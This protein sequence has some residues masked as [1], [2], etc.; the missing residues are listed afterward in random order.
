VG[1]ALQR[2]LRDQ[3]PERVRTGTVHT[4]QGGERDVVIFSLVADE[5]MHPGAIGW[6][7]RQLNLWNVAITRARSHLIVVGDAGLWQQRGGVGAAL[8][9]AS[10]STDAPDRADHDGYKELLKRL[11]TQLSDQPGSTVELDATVNG[12]RADAVT[13]SDQNVQAVLL[14]LGHDVATDAGRH[15]RLMLRRRQLL[16]TGDGDSALRLPAWRLYDQ[17]I[18][19]PRSPRS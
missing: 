17:T 1:E 13:R 7:D 19:L 16:A 6:I 5:G 2:R 8:F 3:D 15:L 4:F 14:D 9:R 18:G 12:H 11:Y 10:A